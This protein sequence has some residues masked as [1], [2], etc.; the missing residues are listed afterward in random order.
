[1]KLRLALL[2]SLAALAL[3]PTSALAAGNFANAG[4]PGA[5]TTNPIAGMKWGVYRGTLDDL[6]SA[7][8]SA[9]GED[10]QLLAKEALQPL[11]YWFGSWNQD[12][13][14]GKVARQY[15]QAQ[16]NGDPAVLSQMAIFRADPWEGASCKELPTAKQV[17]NYKDW[18][19]NWAKGI[20]ASRAVMD[21]QPDMP[22]LNCIPDHS[23]IPA[24]EINDAAK[25]FSA[26]PH[27]TVYIDAGASDWQSVSSVVSLLRESGVQYTRGFALGATHYASTADELL[28]GDRVVRAL[29]AQG[30][31]GMHFIINTAQNGKPFTVQKDL[32]EFKDQNVCAA[33]QSTQ[34][35]TLGIPPTTDVAADPTADGLTKHEVAIAEQFCD[36]YLWFGRPWLENQDNPFKLQRALGLAV[37]TPF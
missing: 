31:T 13:L 17:A 2:V 36:A 30:V 6:Y 37:S 19:N 35:V 15:I 25:A 3:A 9:R 7:W 29:A 22:F 26:L 21:L 16:T 20:G 1:M 24:E 33:T 11:M 34:C 14:A 28:Y 27:T 18:I 4:L 5:S 8:Q 10:K 32:A 12:S 23:Q